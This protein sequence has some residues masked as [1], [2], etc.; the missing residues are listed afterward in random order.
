MMQQ[1]PEARDTQQAMDLVMSGPYALLSDREQ[2]DLLQKRD[3]QSLVQG[4]EHFNNN[5]LAFFVQEGSALLK[6]CLLYTS[7]AAD[8]R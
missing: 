4:K 2:L 5:G 1:A 3:C 6:P 7:D 8:E